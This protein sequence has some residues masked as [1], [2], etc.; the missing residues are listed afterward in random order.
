[1]NLE[2][3]KIYKI[4]FTFSVLF[5]LIIFVPWN[6]L[7]F[8]KF[9]S[10]KKTEIPFQKDLTVYYNPVA[11]KTQAEPE[12]TKGIKK[13]SFTD[14]EQKEFSAD[15]SKENNK[16]KNSNKPENKKTFISEETVKDEIKTK[17]TEETE[18]AFENRN[19]ET[20]PV[21][22]EQ[23]PENQRSVFIQY[24][25]Y[26]RN[27]IEVKAQLNRPDYFKEGQ[28]VVLFKLNSSG[29]IINIKID[30]AISIRD[31]VL[32]Y[33]AVDSVKKASPFPPFPEGLTALELTFSVTIE[34]HI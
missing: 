28:V 14:I 9:K 29:N 13:G 26:I 12:K 1:M 7:F 24:Y 18:I 31:R 6:N 21:G 15:L 27:K 5:H 16:N 32:R 22:I 23:V 8:F 17:E 34:F 19:S 33:S 4:A 3:K 20:S 2:E 25:K 11:L 10:E 30:D